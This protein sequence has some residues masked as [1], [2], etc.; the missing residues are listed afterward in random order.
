MIKGKYYFFFASF[1]K[2]PTGIG[3]YKNAVLKKNS[4][5]RI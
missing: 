5:N 2:E 3:L 4:F 1:I